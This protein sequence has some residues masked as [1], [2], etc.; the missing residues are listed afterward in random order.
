LLTEDVNI[1]L[2]ECDIEE[3]ESI[4]LLDNYDENA[5]AFFAGFIAR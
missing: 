1:L 4:N 2:Q 3:F 5:I